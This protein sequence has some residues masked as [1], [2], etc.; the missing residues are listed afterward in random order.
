[1]YLYPMAG[2]PAGVTAIFVRALAPVNGTCLGYGALVNSTNPVRGNV[3]AKTRTFCLRLPVHVVFVVTI[4]ANMMHHK[5]KLNHT[6][7]L[8]VIGTESPS[9]SSRQNLRPRRPKS[10]SFEHGLFSPFFAF[11]GHHFVFSSY[12]PD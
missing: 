11:S 2:W 7:Q 12:N 9:F 5:I 3:I 1:M 4:K 10:P 6:C 8:S